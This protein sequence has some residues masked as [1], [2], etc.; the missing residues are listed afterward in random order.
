M[1]GKQI[2][3]ASKPRQECHRRRSVEPGNMRAASK[4]AVGSACSGVMR[5]VE[6]QVHFERQVEVDRTRKER[7]NAQR[8]ADQETEQIE[9]RPGHKT[10]RNAA[11]RCVDWNSRRGP[12]WVS[13]SMNS[14]SANLEAADVRCRAACPNAK[15]LRD[16]RPDPEYEESPPRAE[17]HVANLR[18]PRWPE[19]RGGVRDRRQIVRRRHRARN[20][21]WR[22]RRAVRIAA[23]ACSLPDRPPRNL[24]RRGRIAP[25]ACACCA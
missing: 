16:V 14:Y 7:K 25:A 17:G 10:P 4:T 20:R 23:R 18:V 12:L 19:R 9:V 15:P 22:Q 8:E 24:D 3:C 11:P 13:Y 6:R 5:A 2:A 21:F 1:P